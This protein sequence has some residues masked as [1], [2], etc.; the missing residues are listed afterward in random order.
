M[1]KDLKSERLIFENNRCYLFNYKKLTCIETTDIKTLSFMING[2]GL[3][4]EKMD[5]HLLVISGNI[6]EIKRIE[7]K[8]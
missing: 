4:I 1:Y 7:N 8:T 5:K 3:K 6:L 2:T